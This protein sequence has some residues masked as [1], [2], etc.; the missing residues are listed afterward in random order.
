[1]SDE[2]TGWGVLTD[3]QCVIR[4]PAGPQTF[5]TLFLQ[6]KGMLAFGILGEF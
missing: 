2:S 3:G 1:M 4:C 6:W 5:E